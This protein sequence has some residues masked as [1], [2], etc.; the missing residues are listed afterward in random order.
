MVDV[1]T[2]MLTSDGIGFER[3]REKDSVGSPTSSLTMVTLK[4]T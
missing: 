4:H 1:S 2:E 3:V